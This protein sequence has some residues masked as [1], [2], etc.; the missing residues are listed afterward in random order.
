ML[1][2]TDLGWPDPMATAARFAGMSGLCLLDSA[3][4]HPALGRYSYL[5]A[6]PFAVARIAGGQLFWNGAPCAG[7]PLAALRARLAPLQRTPRAG[8][9][10]FQGGALGFFAYEFGTCLERLP[11][12]DVPAPGPQ[13][14]FGVHDW[15]IAWDHLTRQCWLVS[16]GA[17]E[18]GAGQRSRALLRRDRIL[19]RLASPA[20]V[21]AD[22]E[23]ILHW[24]A[25]GTRAEH[26]DAVRRAIDYVL[27]GDIF[28]ANIARRFT[29]PRSAGFSPLA[30]YR[31]LR[32]SNPAPFAAFL[33]FG[34]L[35]IAS[36]SPERFL[37]L[38]GRHVEA[39]P[40]KGTVRRGATPEEDAARTRALAASDK[41]RAENVMI[42]D[43]MRNDLSRVARPRSVE[44]PVLCGVESYAGLHHLVS[45]VTAELAP[46]HDALDLIAATFPGG[47]ITGAPKLRAMEIITALE[48]HGRGPYCGSIGWL[49][50]DGS[51]D[52][53][54]AIR[55]V[56]FTAS[57]AVFQTGGGITALSDPAEEFDETGTKAN[58][59]LAA[60]MAGGIAP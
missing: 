32:R 51:F 26:E 44:V 18:T 53:N 11:A 24:Q 39:R 49:G 52:F 3:M 41:E 55:T 4:E 59:I 5:S 23:D 12:P 38:D 37:R 36:S 56:T 6:D 1:S 19:A 29:A 28:Q 50:F 7:A 16:T 54:I 17:P 35:Q 22:D 13:A 20:P 30:Y 57:E 46:A 31:R 9:P 15:V 43:L 48:R 45:V 21:P 58:R 2:V 8:L 25:A 40:I 27:A 14:A 60:S 33:D 10:P 47:S 34:D 42:V